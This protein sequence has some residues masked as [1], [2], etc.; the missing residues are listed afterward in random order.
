MKSHEYAQRLRELGEFLL[1]KPEFETES[2]LM[3]FEY[4][5]T[6]DKFLAAAR[7]IGSG[8]KEYT[9][10]DFRFKP[11]G[12]NELTL[13]ISRD[14]VCRKVQEEK[15]EC[16]PILSPEEEATVGA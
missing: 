12:F 5:Y 13:Y 4:F 15:W 8:S 7:A 9:E 2:D 11:A 6:K 1:T 10:S 14:K 16:E 3:I